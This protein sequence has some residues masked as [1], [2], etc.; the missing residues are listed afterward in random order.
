M[1][2]INIGKFQKEANIQTKEVNKI[3][4]QVKEDRLRADRFLPQQKVVYNE[5]QIFPRSHNHLGINF[6]DCF[7][8]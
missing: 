3:K 1:K 8:Q 4:I 7:S 2:P 5:E 6:R